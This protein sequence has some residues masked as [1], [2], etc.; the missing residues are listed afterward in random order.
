MPTK[1]FRSRIG[2]LR[3]KLMYYWKPFNRRKLRKFYQTFIPA[4]SLC[5]DIG[6]HLG[7]RVDAFA[8]LGAKVIAVEPQPLCLEYLKQRFGNRSEVKIIPKAVGAAPGKATLHISQLAPTVSTLANK[9]WRS[10]LQQ[11]SNIQVD[12]EDQLEVELITLDQLIELY[13][14]PVFCKIDV[15]DYEAE[16]LKGLSHAIPVISFEF[17]TWT[18][19]RTRECI[20][21]LEAL[22]SYEYNW[23][24][25]EQQK[26]VGQNWSNAKDL[27]SDLQKLSDQFSGDVYA[28][29]MD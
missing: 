11:R 15:E 12:W 5:F 13:G 10:E 27:L 16:V 23:S 1:N 18:P 29:R 20:A 21:L 2:I 28:R 17:F 7:N 9:E 3:S 25:G 22:G 24:K 6:A 4:D 14:M 26:M 19:E 8:S